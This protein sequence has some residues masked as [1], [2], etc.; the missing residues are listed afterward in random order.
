[1]PSGTGLDS[2]MK[3]FPKRT[4]DVGIAE[5]HAVT[6]AAGLA[7]EGLKP[8]ATIYSTF[9]QRAYD[10]VIHDVAIQNLPVRFAIDR[11]GLVGADGPT[12]AGSFDIAYL[13]NLPNFVTM[14]ASDE[15][16]LARMI[17]TCSD[18]NDSPSAFRYP[19][20]AGTGINIDFKK[21]KKLKIGKGK[22]IS[23]GND[24]I[25]LSYGARLSEVKKAANILLEEKKLH[26]QLLMPDFANL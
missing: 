17:L 25:L 12:H 1:M 3:K 16:E 13:S 19:R 4:F 14:A 26:L 23:E 2:F 7:C 20:G 18:I 21:I 9:L 10:Q 22:I 6:F 11:A 24:I 8:F 15:K 5:Q